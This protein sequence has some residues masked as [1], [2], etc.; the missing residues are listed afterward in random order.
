MEFLSQCLVQNDD[1][2]SYK[3]QLPLNFLLNLTTQATLPG[4]PKSCNHLIRQLLHELINLQI[5]RPPKDLL[6]TSSLFN[7]C[8]VEIQTNTNREEK[9]PILISALY[10]RSADFLLFIM[11]VVDPLDFALFLMVF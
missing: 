10:Q 2:L 6:Q 4:L 11:D 1:F 7:R 3:L 9:C 8:K 5:F